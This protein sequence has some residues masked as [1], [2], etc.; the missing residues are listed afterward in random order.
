L[1][2]DFGHVDDIDGLSGSP[3]FVSG[4]PHLF[5]GVVIR[6]GQES[7]LLHFIYGACLFH[8]M[9]A[10]VEFPSQPMMI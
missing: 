2:A 1:R 5:V 4:D 7:G 10:L 8:A 3:V 9:D 6:A